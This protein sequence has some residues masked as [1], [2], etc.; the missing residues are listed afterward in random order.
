M[1]F[2]PFERFNPENP[3]EDFYWT[4]LRRQR[5]NLLKASDY[6]VLPDSPLDQDAWKEYRQ[7]LRDLPES[8]K[9]PLHAIFPDKP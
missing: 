5:D 4:E 9:D 2:N 8:V 1:Q 3:D 7:S 6:T